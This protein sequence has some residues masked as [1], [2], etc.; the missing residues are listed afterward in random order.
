VEMRDYGQMREFWETRGSKDG[1]ERLRGGT[2][3]WWRA[4][5]KTLRENEIQAQNEG[6]SS[7]EVFG[8]KKDFGGDNV[9]DIDCSHAT[10]LNGCKDQVHIYKVW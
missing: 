8:G 6:L 9:G 4:R 1:N 3:A 2:R 7:E 10:L 5:N